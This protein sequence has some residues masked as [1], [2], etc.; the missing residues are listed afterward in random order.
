MKL[1]EIELKGPFY[2]YLV[3]QKNKH[4]ETHMCQ[5]FLGIFNYFVLC[6]CFDAS[7][8]LN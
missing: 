5:H 1:F 6:N 4:T 8:A 7:L 2:I 3:K